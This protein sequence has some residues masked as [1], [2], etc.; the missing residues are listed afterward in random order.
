MQHINYVKTLIRRQKI[1]TRRPKNKNSSFSSSLNLLSI[2]WIA[3]R[4]TGTSNSTCMTKLLRPLHQLQ[5][6]ISKKEIRCTFQE[7]RNLF[8]KYLLISIK[9]I[10]HLKER[11]LQLQEIT[12]N[13]MTMWRVKLAR[14]FAISFVAL[15]SIQPKMKRWV[16]ISPQW[17]HIPSPMTKIYLRHRINLH[18]ITIK[19]EIWVISLIRCLNL[20]HWRTKI[21]ETNLQPSISINTLSRRPTSNRRSLVHM[22]RWKISKEKD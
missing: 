5:R 18:R 6:D 8:L 10:K 12:R 2:T 1:F 16:V 3:S 4:M 7:S 14:V 22:T 17:L 21:K 9:L 11:S 20:P 19:L 13:R 15:V